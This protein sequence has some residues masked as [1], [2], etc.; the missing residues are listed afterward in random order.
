VT[1]IDVVDVFPCVPATTSVGTCAVSAPSTRPRCTTGIPSL[2][3]S[4]SSTLA[5]GTAVEVTTR[6]A[7]CTCAAC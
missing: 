4:V 7:P 5:E 1:T 6:S 2:R 3:A